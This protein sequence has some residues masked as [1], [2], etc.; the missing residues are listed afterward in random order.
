MNIPIIEMDQGAANKAYRDYRRSVLE[1]RAA[2][3]ANLREQGHLLG[4]T[5][6][7]LRSERSR[8]ERED[9]ELMLAHKALAAGQRL[10]NLPQVMR[11]AGV[12]LETFL[13]ALAIAR[14]DWTDCF[15]RVENGVPYFND[16]RDIGYAAR[17]RSIYGTTDKTRVVRLTGSV[18]PRETV[19][20]T[21]RWSRKLYY[22][23]QAIVPSVPPHLRPAKLGTYFILWDAV[24]TPAPPADPLLLKR[25]SRDIFA[26]VAQWDL[27]PLE[28]S[29][30]E[31]RLSE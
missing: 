15:F 29:I 7:M 26:I 19:D 20:F 28:Q 21:W 24:W 17:H 18:F 9:E 23:V 13:P 4:K 14:A 1:S 16:T 12:Q 10:I 2:R 11:T 3:R 5:I 31:G 6:R 27:T 22:P 30:L 25:V 8:M